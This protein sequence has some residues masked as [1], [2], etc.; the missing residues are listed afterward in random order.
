MIITIVIY[1][2]YEEGDVNSQSFAFFNLIQRDGLSMNDDWTNPVLYFCD[3]FG[4]VNI[5]TALL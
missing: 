1:M 2:V 4:I 5:Y 3:S